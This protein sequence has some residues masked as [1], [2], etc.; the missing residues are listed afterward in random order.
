[1]SGITVKTE[2]RRIES[3]CHEARLR[4]AEGSYQGLRIA[5]L[6]LYRS[7]PRTE[8]ARILGAQL[9]RSSTSIGANYRAACRGRSRAEFVAKLGIVLEEADE[10]VFW[11]ELFQEGNIFPAEKLRDLLRE[12]NELVSI[13]VSSVRTAR[14]LPLQSDL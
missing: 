9:L 4:G 1:V 10:A 5:N 2:Y 7:L 12:A 13:F 6:R 11:L 8:E 3:L 14:G